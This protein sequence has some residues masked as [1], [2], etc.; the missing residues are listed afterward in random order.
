MSLTI[1]QIQA[2]GIPSNISK[3]NNRQYLGVTIPNNSVNLYEAITTVFDEV[4][5]SV[6]GTTD[7]SA[8]QGLTTVT[9]GSS[10][11][12]D[13]V[14]LAADDTRAGVMTADQATNLD[15]L[16]TLTGVTGGD[17]DLGTFTGTTISDNT[18]IKNALQELETFVEGVAGESAQDA[19]GSILTDTATI[20]FTYNDG[21]NTITADVKD[22]SITF[23]KMQDISTNKLLGRSTAST[24]AVEQISIGAGLSLAA[25]TLSAT[26]GSGTVTSVAATVPAALLAVSG[27]PITSSGTL[28]FS[29]N[30][31]TGNTVF[32]GPTSGSS[33][34]T[35]RALIED[36]IPSLSA[37]KVSDFSE[38]VDD[39]VAALLVEGTGITLTYDDGSDTLTIDASGLG[40]TDEEAQD[41]VGNIL[42]N[43]TT[44]TFSYSDITPSIS[45]GVNSNSISNTQLTSGAGGIYKGSGT[46]ASGTASTVTASSTYR[47]NYDG[48]N[49]GL[50]IDDLNQ[51][52]SIF[53]GDGTQFVSVDDTQVYIGSG[54]SQMLYIDGVLRLYDS[55]ATNYISIATPATGTLTADYSM[56]LPDSNAPGFLSN[57]GAGNLSWD[58]TTSPAYGE[59]YEDNGS[60]AITVTTAGT[61]YQ[62][63]SST[64]GE[65][66]LVTPSATTDD[67]TIDAGGD[68]IYQVSIQVSF[69]GENNAIVSWAAFKNG[70]RLPNIT[71]SRKLGTGTDIGVVSMT[72]LVD[73]A[74]GDTIDLRVTSDNDA[75][76]VTPKYANLLLHR[77]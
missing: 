3:L 75:D 35:F 42:T 59:L 31:V 52:T 19:V 27:S 72:G 2:V 70:S 8:T 57:D 51:A 22:S 76:T 66:A 55:D 25:G 26:G 74:E 50:I 73:L 11:G 14:V 7:L 39:R 65:Y 24:G 60:T 9:I 63:A 20:D 64:V 77:L 45:A 58:S 48:G 15:A 68:G 34:P 12:D 69:T 49:T 37:S 1:E 46:I 53:S 29:L 38:A 16:V 71:C 36:D 61:Y 5:S 28:A 10:S 43:S 44:I 33:T 6:D 17:E 62:W 56:V 54:T 13:V 40:Y 41:A 32:A 67:I 47:V 21:A 30:T 18:T 4:Y 23:A